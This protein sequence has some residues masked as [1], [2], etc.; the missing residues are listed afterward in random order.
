MSGMEATIIPA[1]LS[2]GEAA[3]G[4]AAS[5][6]P[7]GMANAL[8]ASFPGL[9]NLIPLLNPASAGS[10]MGA[11]DIG[12]KV[13]GGLMGLG[14]QVLPGIATNMLSPQQQP[15]SSVAYNMPERPAGSQA[16]G[17]RMPPIGIGVP[18]EE[19]ILAQLLGRGRGGGYGMFR[20]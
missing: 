11:F 8:T 17:G 20:S 19:D 1:L 7:A 14:K 12:S 3:G 2:A 18:S 13:G 9:T 5:M 16:T 10:A 6:M 15:A 4:F